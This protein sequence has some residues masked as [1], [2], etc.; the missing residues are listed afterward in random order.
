MTGSQTNTLTLVEKADDHIICMMLRAQDC[1]GVSDMCPRTPLRCPKRVPTMMPA[2]VPQ[3]V[4][5]MLPT[6]NTKKPTIKSMF[7]SNVLSLCC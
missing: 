4:P 3:R 7:A 1:G 2:K 6:K 5:I